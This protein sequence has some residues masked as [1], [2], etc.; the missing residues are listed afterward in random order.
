[1]LFKW[2]RRYILLNMGSQAPATVRP[3]R[4][5][6]GEYKARWLAGHG[7]VSECG[8]YSLG[9]VKGVSQP[10]DDSGSVCIT[11]VAFVCDAR[12]RL[13]SA[14]CVFVCERVKTRELR[15]STLSRWSV[16]CRDLWPASRSRTVSVKKTTTTT[17]FIWPLLWASV[18]WWL[19][20]GAFVRVG[21]D[22]GRD[23]PSQTAA[24]CI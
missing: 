20:V 23:A 4:Y 15:V 3:N 16:W 21:G 11:Y 5:S 1:M 2:K 10:K 6:G 22:A 18:Y 19:C 24:R 9:C 12:L 13:F 14:V 17:T 8:I 7:C